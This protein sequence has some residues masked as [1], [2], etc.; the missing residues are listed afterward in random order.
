[1]KFFYRGGGG[2]GG[3]AV[4]DP[5]AAAAAAGGGASAS[6]PPPEIQYV[7]REVSAT[8]AG[9]S[10][11]NHVNEQRDLI[12]RALAPVGEEH[13]LHNNIRDKEISN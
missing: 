2:H 13:R 10:Y 8:T 9:G 3:G 11:R 1:M 12:E 5:A 6:P 4:N 7:G